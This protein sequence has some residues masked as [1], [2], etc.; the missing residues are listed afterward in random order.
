MAA[1]ERLIVAGRKAIRDPMG[2][3]PAKPEALGRYISQLQC[4]GVKKRCDTNERA[5]FLAGEVFD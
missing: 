1:L 4:L 5:R 3:L 2:C